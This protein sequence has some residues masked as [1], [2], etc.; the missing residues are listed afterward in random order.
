MGGFLFAWISRMLQGAGGIARVAETPTVLVRF[1][2][3]I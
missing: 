3:T 1:D 2:R